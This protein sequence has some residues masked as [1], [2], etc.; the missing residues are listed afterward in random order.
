MKKKVQTKKE[1]NN[2]AQKP[3]AVAEEQQPASVAIQ[4]IPPHIKMWDGLS[5]VA[6]AVSSRVVLRQ[7]LKY[8]EGKKAIYM[9]GS[10]YYTIIGAVLNLVQS[11]M[12]DCESM[13]REMGIYRHK[14]KYQC[15][16]AKGEVDALLKHIKYCIREV[17]VMGTEDQKQQAFL[18][19]LDAT[20]YIRE[21]LQ[22]KLDRI[23]KVMDAFV[24]KGGVEK[25]DYVASICLT[26]TLIL[27]VRD[28]LYPDIMKATAEITGF[29]YTS[30][31]PHGDG[32][33][34][35]A[36]WEKVE[37]S[38]VW[39]VFRM[40]FAESKATR[41]AFDSFARS[42]SND[43]LYRKATTYAQQYLPDD[44]RDAQVKLDKQLRKQDRERRKKLKAEAE[45]KKEEAEKLKTEAE[46]QLQKE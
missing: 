34:V 36:A 29:D 16:L 21:Q 38:E 45:K 8:D 2:K 40:D 44:V 5:Y 27:F 12:V 17:N 37:E 22:P 7:S 6:K 28:N 25:H 19:W 31:F 39:P 33:K 43:T 9:E 11:Q 30:I 35:Y 46:R 23:L 42:F 20:D 24:E 13:M 3:F 10:Y 4:D 26:S 41:R 15:K 32:A 18:F 14:L 1:G